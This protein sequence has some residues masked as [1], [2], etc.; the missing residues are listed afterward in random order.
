M[1]ALRSI[2]QSLSLIKLWSL[3]SYVTHLLVMRYLP[4]Y[5]CFNFIIYVDGIFWEPAQREP[6]CT[7]Y[8]SL[9]CP[10]PRECET[11]KRERLD[12]VSLMICCYKGNIS[13]PSADCYLIRDW[14]RILWQMEDTPVL[15]SVWGS[16]MKQRTRKIILADN[17]LLKYIKTHYLS[18]K[19]GF[20]L[21]Q[22]EGSHILHVKGF[23]ST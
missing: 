10:Q 15:L 20:V 5:A 9:I 19:C 7:I 16:L 17:A 1:G 18:S 4:R 3:S 11:K 2:K 21:R 8:I 12:L 23:F 22:G 6:A 13:P 14:N